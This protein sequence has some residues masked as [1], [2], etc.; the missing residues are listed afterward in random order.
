MELVTRIE[1]FHPPEEGKK[2]EAGLFSLPPL[3][4]PRFS[5]QISINLWDS[6]S[7]YPTGDLSQCSHY[8]AWHAG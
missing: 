5:R 3:N 8:P 6:P 1:Q 4:Q 7:R 2:K